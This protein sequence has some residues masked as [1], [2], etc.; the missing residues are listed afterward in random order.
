MMKSL[1]L[2]LYRCCIAVSCLLAITKTAWAQTDAAALVIPKN[3]FCAGIM[4]GHNSWTDYWEGTYKRDNGNIGK[5]TTNAYTFV[6]NYG[7]TNKIDLLFSVPYITTNASAG[8]LKGQSGLQDITVT[9]KWLAY[10]G[11][12]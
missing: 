4:Y 10:Q 9:L 12:I 6:G 3:Y 7:L 8:T 1:H 2:Y 11:E 5:L